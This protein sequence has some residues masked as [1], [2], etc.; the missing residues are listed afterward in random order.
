MLT[1]LLCAN[2]AYAGAI[3]TDRLLIVANSVSVDAAD[4]SHT[5]DDK[6][7]QL[8]TGTHRVEGTISGTAI[9][10]TFDVILLA[11]NVSDDGE[12]MKLGFVRDAVNLSEETKA[13]PAT[14]SFGAETIPDQ[15]YVVNSPITDL[16]LPEAMSGNRTLTYSV[17][18]TLPMEPTFTEATRALSG[19]PTAA[20][21]GA[22]YVYT[23]TDE[24][25]DEVTLELDMTVEE[26]SAT[27]IPPGL[28][29]I[30]TLEQLNAM[31]YDSDGDG[32]ADTKGDLA[33]LA[34]ATTAYQALFPGLVAANEYTGYKLENNLDFNQ[35]ASYSNAATNKSKWTPNSATPTNSGWEPIGT[36]YPYFTGTFDG[37][38]KTISNL[39]INRGSTRYVGLFGYVDSG[40]SV[41][42]VGLEDPVVTGRSSV[43][44]L[45]GQNSRGTISASYVSG[46]TVTGRSNVGGLVGANDRGLITACYVSGGTVTAT[47]SGNVGG[48][49]GSSNGT[50]SAS[51]VSGGTVTGR[52]NVGSL[53]GWNNSGSSIT[54]SYAG[55]KNYANL[56]GLQE[57]TVTNSYYQAA[58]GSASGEA[59][60]VSQ[61][62]TP[63]STNG[64]YAGWTATQW[65][66]GGISDYPKLKVDFNGDNTATAAEFGN[67]TI[68]FTPPTV[69]FTQATRTVTEGFTV[70][71]TVSV[72]EPP[73]EGLTYS[74]P[75]VAGSSGTTAQPADYD[76]PTS[77]DISGS[78]TEGTFYTMI[79]VDA[80]DA[81]EILEL[82][83][84]ST[85]S[86]KVSLNVG[87]QTTTQITINEP[88]NTLPTVE[89][90]SATYSADEGTVLTVTVEVSQAPG[91]GLKY[92]IPVEVL[93]TAQAAQTIDYLLSSGSNRIDVTISG[94]ERSKTFDVIL[95][96]DNVSDN[97][98][99]IK[100]GF[101]MPTAI[102]LRAGANATTLITI[103]NATPTPMGLIP[104]TNLEQLNAIR[105]D[106][107]GDGKVDDAGG[108][109][110]IAAAETAY[111]SLF[112][113][114]A[115]D[116]NDTDK[117]TGYK[118]ENNLDFSKDDHYL[119]KDTNKSKWTP[120]HPTT[121]TNAGWV[122][123]G[124]SYS[125]RFTG[126]F[127]GQGNTISNLFINRG[128]TNSVGL[129]GNVGSGG[130]VKNV[131]LIGPV[132][133]GD[134]IVGGLV[135]YSQGTISASYVSGGT[136]TGA[137]D[138]R[139]TIGGLVG[140]GSAT[141]S[142]VSG[143]TVTGNYSIGGLVGRG[144]AT[145]SYVSGGTVTGS[146][147]VGGLVGS[148]SATASYV[149]GVTVTG[150]DGV[151]GLVGENDYGGPISA[152][153]VSGGTVTGTGDDYRS[154]VGGLVGY[155]RSSTISASYVSGVT[156]T[157][158]GDDS[159]V[160]SL[161]G[162]NE[163]ATII[164]SYAGGKNYA[165]LV[166]YNEYGST[167]TNS[168]YQ[169]ATG[170]VSGEAKTVSQLRTP[171]GT[172]TGIYA[173]WTA[174]QWNFG[175]TS[176]F[177]KLLADFNG[178]SNIDAD[179]IALQTISYT[180]PTVSFTQAT[181]TVTEG[182]TV[183]ITVSVSE[184]PG[185][186]LTY[187][188]P[189]V[190]GTGTTAQ[191]ADYDLPRSVDISGSDTEGTFY[192][193]IKV[194][195]AEDPAEILVLAF[196]NMLS[197]TVSLNAGSPATTQVTINEAP[198]TLPTVEFGSA[199]YS[200]DEG[201][202]LT[203][204]VEVSEAPGVGLK[205]VIPIKVLTSDMENTAE[206]A[207]YLLPTEV[208]ISGTAISGTFDVT[209][210]VDN[211]S[212][213]EKIKLGF[214][215]P[216]DVGLS[217]GTKATT[218][219]TINNASPTADLIPI[220]TLEQL[221]AMRYD[222]DGDGVADDKGDLED[223]AAATTAY[224]ALFP[225]LPSNK[226]YTGYKLANN[227]DFDDAGSYASGAVDQNWS[228]GEGGS[229]WN[230][231]GTSSRVSFTGTFDGQGKT[232]SNLF[233]NRGSTYDV[234]L[235]GYVG[236]GGTVKNVGLMGPVVTGNYYVGGLV[237]R[238]GSYNNTGGSISACYVSG[239]TVTGSSSVGG[240]V[241]V[242]DKGAI[243]ASYVSGGTVT[244]SDGSI[245]G[246]VGRNNSGPISVS[247][248]AGATVTGRYT[249]GGLVG[250]NSNGGTVSACYVS[251]GTVTGNT[252]GSLVGWNGASI[253]ACYAGG[254]HY[255]NLVGQ[256]NGT[257]TN[258][259]YQAAIGSVSGEAKTVSQLRTPMDATTG[260][261][262]D[263][264]VDLDNADGDNMPATGTDDFWRFGGDSDFPK[265]W[266]DFN[267]DGVT[268]TDDIALQ[269]ISYTVPT[270]S[271]TQATYT[272]T[273]GLTASVTVRISEAPG[274]GLTYSIPI[275][276]GS[277]T[278]AQDADYDITFPTSVDISG[279]AT[280]VTF[281]IMI[282]VDA[283]DAGE[284]L[285]LA[286]D[287][288]LSDK[289]S[290]KAGSTGHR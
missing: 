156:V 237:G 115:Y 83:F 252:V 103:N 75:I 36:N 263:W 125:T 93:T 262:A 129:F 268:D 84:G 274:A 76:L 195:A 67:Q 80:P 157:G 250:G 102:G 261:Y 272:V 10:E 65:N 91:A 260:I 3:T 74:I 85:L 220:T 68:T 170:S 224:Q 116:V 217:A 173:G 193:M 100:L 279:S 6:D 73:G 89:F 139:S 197:D 51:Y 81:G 27:S 187:S 246:L 180:V 208:M 171:T 101:D 277:G 207:D 214:D 48:L 218:L 136:V 7:Y 9:S 186:G 212:D 175:T 164:A 267:G 140:S 253:I 147:R 33:D 92:V 155:N 231:I 135:G 57:G 259:Y 64:I 34:T 283:A 258:S 42:N 243:S 15:T 215:M 14:P 77:V 37:Q 165:N 189:I 113:R 4:A 137:G 248:V 23:T 219:I 38:G 278:N 142:Y 216:A 59:K 192:T 247:Y 30:T 226:Y 235:F 78:D 288:M 152:C 133:T 44:G 60:T 98:E 96:G 18:P 160:G 134:Q 280:E 150:D 191:P 202:V 146:S 289:V 109:A 169:A 232:I 127:D 163:Y 43:G 95:L 82:A 16:A 11:D 50:I 182:F 238:N 284:K 151:G 119:D 108:L 88:P 71:I 52:S 79:K 120:D 45:V 239:G 66:F 158:T 290:L 179:D 200:A 122:P 223:L 143:V 162:L 55:G 26:T 25:N 111:V 190:A 183:G 61:L 19:P 201:T 228:E 167:V 22:T 181:R 236:S 265:L 86:D 24:D 46:G 204:T 282:K 72:S 184:A 12:K 41:K 264:D 110:S 210:W 90:E 199:T 276:A 132:V 105:Y 8:S 273:E 185:E 227:L 106:L 245:G 255:A 29:P 149:S 194:D 69:S 124:T 35:N 287:D 145:A 99:K 31:R 285:V 40:G 53:V 159:S 97:G 94:T 153:Y 196:D 209:L 17:T 154:R 168:Y 174:T 1:F 138:Y 87:S 225:S 177:P 2:I 230:P 198:N 28:I 123:I 141:A 234:G 271:F 241:G 70:G 13:T 213:D 130:S 205:Y 249:V 286:F 172:T 63:T 118:L 49:V 266:A 126:T 56:V 240:L 203:V 233:I 188:I 256:Q 257:V 21:E 244:G 229:G 114:V 144:G 112:P 62:R 166:G 107:N 221:S 121:P 254:K 32:V 211:V 47:G 104:V 269:T 54:A 131:G 117:Y 58:T 128:F 178:D 270:V 5:A 176:D 206:A 39:F 161:V 20:A 275:V 281:S 148:G 251:G 222:L 242:N